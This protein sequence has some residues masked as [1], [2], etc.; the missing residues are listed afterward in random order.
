MPKISI[1]VAKN[2][3]AEY[4]GSILKRLSK[5][6][7]ALPSTTDVIT[8]NERERLTTMLFQILPLV[9]YTRVN[10][11]IPRIIDK[12]DDMINSRRKKRIILKKPISPDAIP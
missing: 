11:V 5:K 12:N 10:A 7:M 3:P 1:K 9:K 8:I 6:G 2:G 4:A